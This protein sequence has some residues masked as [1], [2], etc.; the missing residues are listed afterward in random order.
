MCFEEKKREAKRLYELMQEK[1]PDMCWGPEQFM[2]DLMEEVGELSNALL[3]ERGH[4]FRSRQKSTLEDAFFDILF[5]LFLLAD[6]L[7]INLDKAW[8]NEIEAFRRRV[9]TGEFDK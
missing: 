4:K 8:E 6:K 3:V 2:L 7:N 5:D 1:Y 9:V